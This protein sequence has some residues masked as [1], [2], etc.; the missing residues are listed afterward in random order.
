MFDDTESKCRD[1]TSGT[2]GLDGDAGYQPDTYWAQKVMEKG[3]VSVNTSITRLAD[4]YF[5]S[6][7][8][9]EIHMKMNG[10]TL[11]KR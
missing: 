10:G 11:N 1:F 7:A 5:E 3:T 8:E 2:V 9:H 6:L 4:V